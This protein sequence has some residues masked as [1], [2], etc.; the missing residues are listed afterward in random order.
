MVVALMNRGLSEETFCSCFHSQWQGAALRKVRVLGVLGKG[1]KG[2][3]HG[4]GSLVPLAVP[5]RT[6]P[7]RYLWAFTDCL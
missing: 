7:C 2:I 3:G 6:V 5:Y 4:L 1:R